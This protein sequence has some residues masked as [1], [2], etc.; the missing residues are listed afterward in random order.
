MKRIIIKYAS[1][2]VIAIAVVAVIIW[3]VSRPPAIECVTLKESV[4]ENTFNEVGEVIPL[5]EFDLFTKI[6]GK[7]LNVGVTEGSSVKKGDVLFVL[8]GSDLKSEEENILAQMSIVDS[9]MNS[10]MTAWEMQRSSL[11]SER[12]SIQITIQQT[13]IEEKK[14]SENLEAAKMLYE[15]GASAAQDLNNARIAY[16]LAVKNRESLNAQLK[17]LST[18]MSEVNAQIKA[19]EAG[20]NAERTA[21]ENPNHE[22]L[23]QKAALETKLESLRDHQKE[24]TVVAAADGRVRDLIIKEG[25][26]VPPG[27][28]LCSIYQPDKYRVDCHVLVENTEGIG[29]GDGVEITLR[30]RDEDKK[31]AGTIMQIAHDAVERV[32]KVGLSE[33]RIKVEISE[34]GAWENLGPYWPVEVCFITAKS[35]N[36]L[37]V[38]KTAVFE[39]A[40]NIWKIWAVRDG[41]IVGVSVEKGIQT[42][43]QVEIKGDVAHGE[44]IVKN[45]KAKDIS[46]GKSV[47]AIY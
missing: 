46:E 26:I 41:K 11:E 34:N 8:D 25:Q 29:I 19:L 20:R 38:P 31:F 23:A 7:L 6:G 9:Q 42:P 14:L 43:S 33:K 35:K 18:Q 32:S 36:C 5:I 12:S 17:N 2:G 47:R 44:L 1:M 15:N 40:A 45:A 10:Q 3:G 30:L 39:E 13:I 16:E 24:L 37:V 28:K 27:S 4:I 21:G 22:L